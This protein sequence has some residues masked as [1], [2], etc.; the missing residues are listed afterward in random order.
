MGPKNLQNITYSEVLGFKNVAANLKGYFTMTIYRTAYD[1]TIGNQALTEKITDA[2]QEMN[3]RVNGHYPS[4]E[5]RAIGYTDDELVT[6][7]L[8]DAKNT[9]AVP[10]FAHPILFKQKLSG[11]EQSYLFGDARAFAGVNPTTGVISI[12]NSSEYDLLRARTIMNTVWLL[13]NPAYLKDISFVPCAMYASLIADNVARRYALDPKDQMQMAIIAAVFYYTLFS[14][15]DKFDEQVKLKMVPAIVKATRAPSAMILDILDRIAPM[16]NIHDFCS[17]CVSILENPRLQ[18]FNAGVLVTV[19][20]NTW[21]GTNAREI[22][23]AALEHPPT[24]VALCYV[25]FTERT[26]KKSGIATIALRFMGSKGETDFTR[27]FTSLAKPYSG[28]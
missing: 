2:I 14:D 27:A 20:G 9:V 22:L 28:F 7:M 17:N 6:K 3:I 16:S 8:Y 24:W 19:V 18:E 25:A 26:F 12:R 23:A 4:P 21:F 1:T 5:S 10:F 13:R 15:D 11:T